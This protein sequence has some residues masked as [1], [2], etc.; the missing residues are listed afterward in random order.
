[1]KIT[2][3]AG[4]RPN[5]MKV[6]P[7]IKELNKYILNGVPFRYRLVHTGQH[8]DQ[9][10]S[11]N[12]F[13]Q[14]NIPTPDINLACSVG[15]STEQTASIMVNFE[16][17]VI[18]FTP[19]LV[20][21][22]GDVNST[23]A[24]TLVAKKLNILVA[25]VEGGLRSGDLQMPE[26]INRIVTDSITDIFFT[27]S[28]VASEN[29]V[30]NGIPQ[31]KIFFVGNTM[32]DTLF[33][34]QHYSKI[35][36]FYFSHSL[37]LTPYF[38]L[39]LHRPSN[40]DHPD[41]LITTLREISNAC[42]GYKVIFPVHPRTKKM[43]VHH[44]K[45]F[46]NIVI[47]DPQPYFEFIYLIQHCKAVITDSGGITEEATFLK[48]PCLTMRDTTERPETITQG[49][50]VLIGNDFD[51]LHKSIDLILMG[52][53]KESSIPK[54]WDGKTSERIIKIIFEKYTHLINNRL[55]YAQAI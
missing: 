41:K 33:Q 22:V 21:V 40:V 28:E 47:V 45:M 54:L 44:S 1:M 24:C 5:F 2:I 49:T 37:Q 16:K 4:A 13:E 34:F 36:N 19:D 27:T 43:L 50:N 3:V 31:E 30:K 26:E 39:T 14:L 11:D 51:K 48:I 8:Y 17:E 23:M 20:I 15:T 38:I 12:F 32:I 25:H 46:D 10:M 18:D 35:P 55:I 52:K 53:W 42:K 7:I 9:L 6:S 29:L